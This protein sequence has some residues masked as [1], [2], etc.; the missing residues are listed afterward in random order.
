M[1]NVTITFDDADQIQLEELI[2][3]HDEKGALEFL[4]RVVKSRIELRLKSSCRPEFEGPSMG[5]R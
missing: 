2:I 1:P 3:D 4:K 5:V